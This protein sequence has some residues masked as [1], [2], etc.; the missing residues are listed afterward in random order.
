MPSALGV[1]CPGHTKWQHH[2]RTHTRTHARAHT[3][4]TCGQVPAPP[5]LQ[6]GARGRA[7]QLPAGRT[8]ASRPSTHAAR[9]TVGDELEQRCRLR[10]GTTGVFWCD[11]YDFAIHGLM[12]CFIFGDSAC[13]KKITFPSKIRTE[14]N[15]VN[16]IRVLLAARTVA[17]AQM[18]TIVR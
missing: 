9:P 13:C 17:L 14:S 8:P 12:Q 1:H 18:K 5:P 2:A 7:S 15:Y 3:H 10:D 16:S 6:R 4:N 11:K